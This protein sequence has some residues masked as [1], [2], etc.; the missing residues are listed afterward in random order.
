MYISVFVCVL[1]Q[2]AHQWLGML[3]GD[4]VPRGSPQDAVCG[5]L[6]G[7]P[8]LQYAEG[9]VRPMQLNLLT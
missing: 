3:G 7:H 9:E 8:G 2:T 1:K 6:A 5:L 4:H